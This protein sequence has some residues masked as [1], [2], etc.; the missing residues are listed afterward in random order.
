[1]NLLSL[2]VNRIAVHPKHNAPI[3]TMV[4]AKCNIKAKDLQF[5]P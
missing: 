1:M 4:L 2:Q 5:K 3:S